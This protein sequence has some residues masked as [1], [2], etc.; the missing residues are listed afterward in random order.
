MLPNIKTKNEQIR[1]L[2]SLKQFFHYQIFFW[3]G[4][5]GHRLIYI[6]ETS[7]KIVWQ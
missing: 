2:W 3:G 6:S 5:F 1:S 7:I 4:A